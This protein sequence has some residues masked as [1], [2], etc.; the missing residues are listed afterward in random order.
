MWMDPDSTPGGGIL[1]SDRI[2]LYVE[3][4]AMIEPFSEEHL[5]PAS[6][7]LTVGRD[8]WYSSHTSETG[9][10][11]RELKTGEDL[12]VPPNS[13]VFVSTGESLNLPFYMTGRFN[14]KLRLLHEGLLVG[15]GPQIDP[16]YTGP[17]SC[18][19]HNI[20]SE[21]ICLRCGEPFA[22][23]EFQK[24]TP[25]A[26][27]EPLVDSAGIQVIR[28]RGE[29]RELK[30]AR[31]FPC[32]TFR[33]RSLNRKP[34]SG[35]LPVGKVVSSSV[36]GIATELGTVRQNIENKLGEFTKN[37]SSI[38]FALLITLLGVAVSLGTYFYATV[39]WH[40]NAYD[41]AFQAQAETKRLQSQVDKLQARLD[42]LLSDLPKATNS[43]IPDDNAKK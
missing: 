37:I 10:Q 32:L 43:L 7:D 27:R 16:G 25:F 19:L 35:Y 29:A 9:Q 42:D 18:P 8:C 3:E 4:V 38:N 14:L 40:R 41:A 36:D 23:I 11:K 5:A 21:K 30:G 39:N 28:D 1:L 31:G 17:L 6:Y 15:T 34:I 2:R 22:V 24:T 12:I 33:S 20:S 26:Q 13:I